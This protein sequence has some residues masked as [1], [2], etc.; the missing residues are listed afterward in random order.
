VV[1]ASFEF[2]HDTI[3]VSKDIF[4]EEYL[5]E[6]THLKEPCVEVCVEVMLMI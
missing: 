3:V 2:E 4:V 6:E 5:L 1:K